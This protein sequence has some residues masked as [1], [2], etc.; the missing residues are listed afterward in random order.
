MAR[1]VAGSLLPSGIATT[2]S[3][4]PGLATTG[5]GASGLATIG[6]GV[7]GLAMTR[8]RADARS[9]DSSSAHRAKSRFFCGGLA[10]NRRWRGE[11]KVSGEERRGSNAGCCG[12]RL[13]VEI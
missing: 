7:S 9:A 5:S 8:G 1:K 6:S 11:E 13:P 10:A 12:L 4:P 2:G 3:G